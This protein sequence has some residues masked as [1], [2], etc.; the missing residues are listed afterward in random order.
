MSQSTSTELPYAADAELS[1][2]YDEL[3]VRDV[4]LALHSLMFRR[5]FAHNTKRN[6]PRSTSLYKPNSTLHGAWL[7]VLNERTRLK[8]YNYYKA[9]FIQA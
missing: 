1:L 2:S 7:R 3:Q 6:S 8:A 4:I 5:Y 9:C